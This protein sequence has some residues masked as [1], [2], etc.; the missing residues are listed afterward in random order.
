LSLDYLSKFAHTARLSAAI[1]LLTEFRVAEDFETSDYLKE[2]DA[3]FKKLKA[4][5]HSRLGVSSSIILTG[6][7]FLQKKKKSRTMRKTSADD[8]EE[9]APPADGMDVDQKPAVTKRVEYEDTT[10]V[11]DE[12][13]QAALSR[14]RREKNKK[15]KPTILKGEDVAKSRK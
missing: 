13:L 7:S 4:S 6:T 8:D 12:E 9:A 3:G 14:Q 5:F 1:D 2:G 10:F 15:K 11:D